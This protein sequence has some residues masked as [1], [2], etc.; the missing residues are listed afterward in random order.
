MGKYV[1]KKKLTPEQ[2]QIANKTMAVILTICYLV[3]IIVEI[4]NLRSGNGTSFWQ[5][6]CGIYAFLIIS[7][8]AVSWKMGETKKATMYFAVTFVIAYLFLVMNNG[9]VTMV[10]AFPALI[11]FMLYLNSTLVGVGC[12][13][14]FLICTLKCVILNASGR[15]ELFDYG[16][17][18]TLGFM[19]CIYG[20]YK[21]IT[22]LYEF[23]RQDREVIEKE[24]AHR[25][26]VAEKVSVIIEDVANHFV[27][28][29]TGLDGV[30]ESMN[31]VDNSMS[32]ITTSSEGMA[33]EVSHQAERT[34]DIQQRLECT[35]NSA[36]NARKTTDNLKDIISDGLLL[37]DDLEKQSNIVDQNISK[38]SQTVELLVS[39]VQQVSGITDSILNIS[40]QTNLLALNA[41]IEAA[42]AGDAGRGFAVVAD[43]IRKL[44]EETKVST[45]KITE[46]INE[47]KSVTGDTQKG[48][49]DSVKAIGI[50]REKV[51][52][53]TNSF[54]EVGNGMELLGTDVDT[55]SEEVEAV[56]T[57]NGAIVDSI[58]ALSAA[59]DEVSSKTQMCKETIHGAYQDVGTFSDIVEG[60]FVQLQGLA[61]TTQE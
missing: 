43:E 36:V 16:K 60:T 28:V 48:I 37:A 53:V 54:S 30:K 13:L 45:E 7:S 15:A 59:S 41:S 44:A 40:S 57:A 20:S 10:L 12:F 19:I 52:E 31:I 5:F 2:Y 14:V 3:Y 11:G 6:R 39:N 18:I 47:L 27:E 8:L 9:V 55:M 56:L 35:N 1:K 26:E 61:E 17:L 22:I 25:A 38:I 24:A 46:I 42:R 58:A 51:T 23:S 32:D 49:E 50:Q 4:T 34:T 33:S 29:I 21:A